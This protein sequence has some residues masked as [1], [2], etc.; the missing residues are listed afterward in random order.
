MRV[1][2]GWLAAVA[3]AGAMAG[4]AEG[5]DPTTKDRVWVRSGTINGQELN[6]K[7]PA[8]EV[9]AG[10]RLKG[11]VVL[12]VTN[13][14]D[15]KTTFPI[16]I[17]PTWGW[18]SQSYTSQAP[19]TQRHNQTIDYVASV[20][21]GTYRILFAATAQANGVA[22]GSLTRGLPEVR[23]DGPNLTDL[24]DI[25]VR[26]AQE[27]G[28]APVLE[29]GPKG[30]QPAAYG[31]AA[32]TV[33]VGAAKV[34]P[35][36]V[37]HWAFDEPAKVNTV[38]LDSSGRGR[39]GTLAAPASYQ[40]LD[41]SQTLWFD[42]RQ[43]LEAPKDAAFNLDQ[44]TIETVFYLGLDSKNASQ[45][46]VAKGAPGGAMNYVLTIDD[47]N[48]LRLAFRSPG[49]EADCQVVSDAGAVSA[50]RWFKVVG[51]YDGR[52]LHLESTDVET[53]RTRSWSAEAPQAPAKSDRP[54][55][56][57]AWRAENDPGR[58]RD[59]FQGWIDD[60]RIYST[61]RASRAVLRTEQFERG[62]L[63]MADVPS[64][65]LEAFRQDL[66]RRKDYA[67]S[68]HEGETGPDYTY[69]DRWARSVDEELARRGYHVYV[70]AVIYRPDGSLVLRAGAP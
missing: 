17:T 27:F 20:V 10:E 32:I 14:H 49:G 16:Y 26:H 33:Y 70:E 46:V 6:P 37:A 59:P 67:A 62:E 35:G 39:N 3:A 65:R 34:E 22:I 24:L 11:Q 38:V 64:A 53:G 23:W 41:R 54:A 15:A 31:L 12:E 13:S 50:R 69:L 61:C 25:Q 30:Y 4:A 2:M 57:G 56:V 21:P 52:R 19:G 68:R 66:I 42:G 55:T 58:L 51:A 44:F 5:A 29:R 7:A 60:V 47:G 43:C 45:C 28:W 40:T 9:T 18:P 1:G 8:I 36:L 48:R 63:K